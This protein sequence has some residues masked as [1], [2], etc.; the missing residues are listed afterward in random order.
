MCT[1]V[2]WS[3]INFDN[4]AKTLS[5]YPSDD[6]HKLNTYQQQQQQNTMTALYDFQLYETQLSFVLSNMVS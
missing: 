4:A 6:H 5:F 3:L 1:Y 2:L